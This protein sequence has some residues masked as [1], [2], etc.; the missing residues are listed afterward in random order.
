MINTVIS[1]YASAHIVQAVTKHKTVEYQ[2][3][4]GIFSY[5]KIKPEFYFGFETIELD[6]KPIQMAIPEKALIDFYTLM[7]N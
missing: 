3:D 6:G 5:R 1:N 2:N 4:C 7:H